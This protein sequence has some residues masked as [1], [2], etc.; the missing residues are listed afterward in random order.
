MPE[1]LVCLTFDYDNVSP[2]IARDQ[3]TP[4]SPREIMVGVV[5]SRA[6]A[7]ETLS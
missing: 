3:T 4:K 1:H 6:I 7:G 5:W 2:A